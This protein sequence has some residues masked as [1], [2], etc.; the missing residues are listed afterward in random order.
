MEL[1]STEVTLG[2][3]VLASGDGQLTG[4]LKF[5]A[6]GVGS[7]EAESISRAFD[8]IEQELSRK[9]PALAA[10]IPATK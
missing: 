5:E 6:S 10:K 4:S 1:F 2:I 9:G 8:Q 7:S 3:S